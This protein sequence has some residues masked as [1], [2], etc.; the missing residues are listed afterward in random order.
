MNTDNTIPSTNLCLNKT[1]SSPDDTYTIS[2]DFTMDTIDFQPI[3]PSEEDAYTALNSNTSLYTPS[4]LNNLKNKFVWNYLN[5]NNTYNSYPNN[6]KTLYTKIFG[7][8]PNQY[9]NKYMILW[10]YFYY[11]KINPI[12]IF[13]LKYTALPN[14]NN[15][16]KINISFTIGPS[17]EIDDPEIIKYFP[18]NNL[19]SKCLGEWFLEFLKQYDCND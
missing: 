8:D 4:E 14:E 10:T 12:R 11:L 6:A 9:F 1:S 17:I 5:D 15:I 18:N 2:F 3:I 19:N 13:N 16:D 7:C